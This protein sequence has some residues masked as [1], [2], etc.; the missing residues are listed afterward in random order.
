MINQVRKRTDEIVPFQAEKITAAIEKAMIAINIKDKK[1]AKNLTEEIVDKLNSKTSIFY[2]NI[3]DIEQIQDTVEEVL[4]KRNERL[5]KVY[6][7]Y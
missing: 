4:E 3:P 7:L 1:T 6:S 2:K 5:Y